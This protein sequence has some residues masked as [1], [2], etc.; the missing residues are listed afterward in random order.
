MDRKFK[1]PAFKALQ[2]T[3]GSLGIINRQCGAVCARF[4]MLFFF[5]SIN[6]VSASDL[7][8]NFDLESSS[9]SLPDFNNTARITQVGSNNKSIVTQSGTFNNSVNVQQGW[10]NYIFVSQVG[11]DND[12][13]VIQEGD[14][15]TARIEQNGSNNF[16]RIEQFGDDL[17]NTI[18]QNGSNQPMRVRSY[19]T[20]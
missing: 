18:V 4:M 7:V 17:S 3:A 14:R 16:A 12:A 5:L 15:N 9:I 10:E 13:F 2:A 11:S 19:K 6:A 8:S 20:W 1:K